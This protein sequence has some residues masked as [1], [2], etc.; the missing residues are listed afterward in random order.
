[1][2]HPDQIR[3]V[4]AFSFPSDVPAVGTVWRSKSI[5]SYVKIVEVIDFEV[6]FHST[7]IGVY[8]LPQESVFEDTL[9]ILKFQER[10]RPHP[11]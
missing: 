2:F 6:K 4:F 9:P 3:K 11:L 7:D 5:D 1:L 8:P 10:F